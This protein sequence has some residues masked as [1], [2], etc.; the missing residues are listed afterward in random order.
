MNNGLEILVLDIY[1]ILSVL[2]LVLALFPMGSTL[3]L[4]VF[5]IPSK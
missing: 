4:L 2:V 3:V 1:Q 5:I